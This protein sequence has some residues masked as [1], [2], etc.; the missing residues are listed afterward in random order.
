MFTLE[1]LEDYQ[2]FDEFVCLAAGGS[3]GRSDAYGTF[4]SDAFHKLEH[5]ADRPKLLASLMDLRLTHVFLIQEHT[6]VGGNWN[7][8]IS[9]IVRD[10]PSGSFPDTLENFG[11]FETKLKMLKSAISTVTLA[12]A[13]WDK[14]LGFIIL[15]KEPNQYERYQSSNSKKK[16]FRK[17]VANLKNLPKG[18][19]HS[20]VMDFQS[21]PPLYRDYVDRFYAGDFFPDPAV[22]LLMKKIEELDKVRTPEIHGAGSLRKQALAVL[23]IEEAREVHVAINAWNDINGAMNSLRHEF[24]GVPLLDLKTTPKYIEQVQSGHS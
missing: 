24:C 11:L 12:R 16:A 7:T 13:W 1:T 14:Y 8:K 20:L 9:S 15:H 18:L 23:P 19:Q 3:W 10:K 5:R 22:E 6:V 4:M 2:K 21:I 17:I